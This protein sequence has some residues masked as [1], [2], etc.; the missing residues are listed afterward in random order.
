MGFG[1]A[2]NAKGDRTFWTAVIPDSDVQVSNL[3]G[4]VAAMHVANLAAQEQFDIPNS[5][6]NGPAVDATVSFDIVWQGPVTR[7]VSVTDA[8]NGFTGIFFQDQ[9]TI[10]WSASN[11]LGFGFF[12]NPGNASTSVAGAFFAE[13]GHERNGI[14]LPS[15]SGAPASPHDPLPPTLSALQ[16]LPV[17]QQAIASA[18]A[19]GASAAP[20]AVL[21]QVQVHS[22]D[23]SS[24]YLG[25]AASPSSATTLPLTPGSPTSSTALVDH[26]FATDAA[27]SLDPDL[28]RDAFVP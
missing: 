3:G 22:A 2:V 12:A 18:Q 15:P 16:L 17:V 21:N 25:E 5:L 1:D 26:V 24:S 9:A 8:K 14:F 6:A 23:R 13:I 4:G 10:T 20:L 11:A 19:A 27:K 28:F 7:T